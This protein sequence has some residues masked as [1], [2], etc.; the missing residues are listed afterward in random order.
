MGDVL[1]DSFLATRRAERDTFEGK[2]PDEIVRIHRW[3]Y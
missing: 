3:R 2:E 1:F